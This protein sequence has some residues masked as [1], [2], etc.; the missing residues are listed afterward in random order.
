MLEKDIRPEA[1]FDRYINLSRQD[2]VKIFSKKKKERIKCPV[3]RILGKF[4][5]RK[6]SFDYEICSKC[7]SIYNSPRTSADTFKKYYSNSVS[8]KFWSDIF[9]K[10]TSQKRIRMI[11]Q[12]KAKLAESFFDKS[13]SNNLI[14]IGA[15]YGLF[16][17]EIKKNTNLK[18]HAIEPSGSMANTL[19][20]KGHICINGY[21]EDLTK[22]DIPSGNNFFTCFEV[23]EHVHDPCFFL[24][25]INSFLKKNEILLLTTLSGTGLDID[26]LGKS[27]K[28]IQPPYHINFFNPHSIRLLLEKNNYKV[29]NIQTPGKLD[30]NILEN[31]Y[32]KIRDNFW[33]IFIKNS[34]VQEKKNMQ[35]FLVKNNLSSHMLVVAKKIK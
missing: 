29:I 22:K 12:P 28:S 35:K 20:S 21:V 7:S 2:I 10:R 30:I 23:L 11:W 13:R 14:D 16:L 9:Y 26:V 31:N 4:Y 1:L 15:G 24:K 8:A 34:S 5:F 27:S 33:K 18:T 25:K 19:N 3:C 6:D 32:S 17:D